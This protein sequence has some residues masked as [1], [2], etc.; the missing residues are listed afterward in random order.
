MNKIKEYYSR[1]VIHVNGDE[2][3]CTDIENGIF[4]HWVKGNFNDTQNFQVLGGTP[5]DVNPVE[6]AEEISKSVNR[7]SEFLRAF[8]YN[9]LFNKQIDEVQQVGLA[10]AHCRQ[11]LGMSEN[12]F[13]NKCNF[14]EFGS[15]PFCDLAD[16]ES[17]CNEV[18]VATVF[19]VLRTVGLTLKVVPLD[20]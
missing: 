8:H 10:V 7:I 20:N 19:E 11:F 16:V 18:D 12:D 15:D 6:L 17:G 13:V 5:K 14:D 4:V 9:L 1:F 3:E 2:C